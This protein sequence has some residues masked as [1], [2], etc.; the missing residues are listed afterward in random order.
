MKGL[1]HYMNELKI[2][3]KLLLLYLLTFFLPMLVLSVFSV[4]YLYRTLSDW[5]LARSQSSFQ[6]MESFFSSLLVTMGDISDR[7]YVNKAVQ[8]IVGKSYSSPLEVYRDYEA[9][10]F[11][12]DFLFAYE[13]IASLRFYTENQTLLDNSF[14]TKTT[15]AVRESGWYR[16]ALELRGQPFWTVKQDSITNK[17]YLSLVRS[18]WGRIDRSFVGVQSINIEPQYVSGILREEVSEAFVFFDGDLLFASVP[19]AASDLPPLGTVRGKMTNIKWQ[20]GSYGMFVK[21]FSS[22]RSASPLFTFMYLVP[23]E[24]LD[25]ATRYVLRVVIAALL[26]CL[27][28]SVLMILLFSFYFGKRVAK[29]RSGILNVVA[30]RFEIPPSIGGNDEFSDI[31]NAL[32]ETAGNIR[33][34]INEVY[35][36]DVEKGQFIAR[37]NDIRFKMLAAQINP[38]FL[39]NTLEHIRMKSLA[40]GDRDVPFM[41]KILAQMLRYN[42]SVQSTPVP[43]MREIEAVS[44]YL[45]I[46]HKRF[47]RRMSYDIVPLCD[48]RHI[49]ILPLLIQPIV[50]NSFVHGLESMTEGG[51]IYILLAVERG[52]AGEEL[53]ISVQDNGCGIPAERLAEIKDKL[54]DEK[55][56]ELSSSIGMVNVNQRIRLFYGSSY[57]IV[58][59]SR[60][61]KGT[62]VTIRV[63]LVTEEDD[64]QSAHSGR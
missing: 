46:Q 9:L 20:Q 17:R 26:F 50:E 36:R 10:G 40:A 49:L 21:D 4:N 39:F 41:L 55:V 31:Y 28:F 38:H 47:A 52:E 18:V 34:L 60:M 22:S 6:R 12:D 32:Q 14:F 24:Q 5:E 19:Q 62:A 16:Q 48:A 23:R 63:P 15:D 58:I 2:K 51:F 7:L 59:E 33:Q 61:G 11:P 29:V 43:L 1:S 8:A 3:Y 44:N 25:A 13:A 54:R 42:L 27:L 56:E 64:A 37:Q 53:V 57:G 45:V 30:R 35:I